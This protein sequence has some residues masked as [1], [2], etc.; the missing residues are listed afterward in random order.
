ME[1]V[2]SNLVSNALKHGDP[3]R[4]VD[5]KV[6][7]EGSDIVLAVTNDGAPIPTDILGKL[8]EPF[9]RGSTPE[10]RGRR[11]LGLGLYIVR[12][13]ALAHGGSVAVES[14][15]D[16]GTV[17]TVRLPFRADRGGLGEDG[18]SGPIDSAD[19]RSLS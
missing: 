5:V 11:G 19:H 8:F 13:I 12:Q 15:V 10:P 18:P 14:T 16:T 17:F 9:R 6:H 3:G 7:A 1:Q 2:V 4:P